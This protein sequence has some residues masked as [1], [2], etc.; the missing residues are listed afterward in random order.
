[1]DAIGIVENLD[2]GYDGCARFLDLE[3]DG[4]EIRL[5]V[6]DKLNEDSVQSGIHGSDLGILVD[7]LNDGQDPPL[8]FH[9]F[10]FSQ[11]RLLLG[12]R[13]DFMPAA[14]NFVLE[15]HSLQYEIRDPNGFIGFRIPGI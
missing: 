2:A 5:I 8:V 4:I 12:I 1:V 14:G 13:V 9:K 7:G 11:F 15:R 6:A 3:G 10:V